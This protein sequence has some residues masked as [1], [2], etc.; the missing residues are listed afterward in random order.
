MLRFTL[1]TGY[2]RVQH[3]QW[4]RQNTDLPTI[5]YL[6][7]THKVELPLTGSSLLH[8]S[9]AGDGS[10]VACVTEGAERTKLK[11]FSLESGAELQDADLASE[12]T[13]VVTVQCAGEPT[14]VLS[15]RC[16]YMSSQIYEYKGGGANQFWRSA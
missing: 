10:V 12:P 8:M 15:F 16:A 3:C 2:V 1:S 9:L 13:S 5:S 11:Q 7:E 6:A 14:V 4:K